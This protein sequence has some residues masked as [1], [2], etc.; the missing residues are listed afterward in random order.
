MARSRRVEVKA[1]T[2]ALSMLAPRIGPGCGPQLLGHALHYLLAHIT[3]P[4]LA[5][6]H[7]SPQL[8]LA[9]LFS[10]N[11]SFAHDAAASSV[12]FADVR[13]TT[14]S[15]HRAPPRIVPSPGSENVPPPREPGATRSEDWEYA[16]VLDDMG[17]ESSEGEEQE[18]LYDSIPGFD[19]GW[20][21][22]DIDNTSQP[23]SSVAQAQGSVIDDADSN[24]ES[25]S[26]ESE[27]LA[28]TQCVLSADD[29]ASTGNSSEEENCQ[30]A[31]SDTSS[32]DDSST[33]DSSSS[34][35]SESLAIG[36]DVSDDGDD[37]T[38]SW[39][40]NADE[41]S[42][43]SGSYESTFQKVSNASPSTSSPS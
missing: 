13:N 39:P 31:G 23:E 36:G 6:P 2:H 40:S 22:D 12:P 41:R 26:L 27:S 28:L 35:D 43:S 24:L 1:K 9:M 18:A 14:S 10:Y 30:E 25:E 34:D 5:H 19:D 37:E 11:D 16:K 8:P 17:V 38:R 29:V 33:E 3:D 42:N 7:S 21:E 15:P 20:D 32:S 4:R